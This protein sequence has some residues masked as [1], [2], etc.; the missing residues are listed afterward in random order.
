MNEALEMR[1]TNWYGKIPD[2]NRVFTCLKLKIGQVLSYKRLI[3]VNQII[4]TL[5][6]IREGYHSVLLVPGQRQCVMEHVMTH[7]LRSRRSR[8][9]S[10]TS[11]SLQQQHESANQNGD[12]SGCDVANELFTLPA[13]VSERVAVVTLGL[14]WHHLLPRV[15][16][17]RANDADDVQDDAWHDEA[18]VTDRHGDEPEDAAKEL[19]FVELAKSGDDQAKQQGHSSVPSR[20]IVLDDV[21]DVNNARLVCGTAGLLAHA[22]MSRSGVFHN[23]NQVFPPSGSA[24]QFARTQESLSEITKFA[25]NVFRCLNATLQRRIGNV[26]NCRQ[27]KC[28]GRHG[29]CHPSKPASICLHRFRTANMVV[30][31]ASACAR[32]LAALYLLVRSLKPLLSVRP[33]PP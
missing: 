30:T 1:R 27:V 31:R 29:G 28:A 5:A 23:V 15:A 11:R 14:G 20:P 18:H 2:R 17:R 6:Y 19:A 16:G 8:E 7:V 24:S 33:R 12:D 4:C 25:R 10:P 9:F 3:L 22:V 26:N 32:I 21:C 13:L